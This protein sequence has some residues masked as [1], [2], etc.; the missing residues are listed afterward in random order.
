M[1]PARALGKENNLFKK[2]LCTRQRKKFENCLSSASSEGTRQR[3]KLKI[4]YRVPPREHSAK[5][6]KFENSLSSA[7][8]GGTRQ[9]LGNLQMVTLPSAISP[10]LGKVTRTDLFFLFLHF[11]TTNTIYYIYFTSFKDISDISHIYHIN[12]TSIT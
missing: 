3:K 2:I 1:P 9:K 12:L 10:A 6:K 7:P 8:S 5:K 11:T 4:V